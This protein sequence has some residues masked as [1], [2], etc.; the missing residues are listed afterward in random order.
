M[1]DPRAAA[2]NPLLLGVYVRGLK[3]EKVA[4]LIVPCDVAMV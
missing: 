4:L 1:S 2:L 3:I